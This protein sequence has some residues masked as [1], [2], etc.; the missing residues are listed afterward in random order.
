MLLDLNAVASKSV[1]RRQGDHRDALVGAGVLRIEEGQAMNVVAPERCTVYC[2]VATDERLQQSFNSIDVQEEAG[3]AS[4]ASQPAEG[5]TTVPDDCTDPG[6]V[7]SGPGVRCERFTAASR[8]SEDFLM[9]NLMR[10]RQST[11]VAR[12]KILSHATL[13]FAWMWILTAT[14]DHRHSKWSTYQ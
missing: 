9:R 7:A 12:V 4:V 14:K 10:N 6:T 3:L 2:R 11:E 5:W 13:N 8:A 1:C